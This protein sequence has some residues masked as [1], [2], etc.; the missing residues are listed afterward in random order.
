[1]HD[2]DKHFKLDDWFENYIDTYLD[3]DVK[4]QINAGNVNA[5]RKFIQVC[6]LYSGQ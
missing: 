4:E 6:A 1:M 2:P 3:L 5:F